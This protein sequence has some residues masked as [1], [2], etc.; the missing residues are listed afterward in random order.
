MSLRRKTARPSPPPVLAL[1]PVLLAA[2]AAAAVLLRRRRSS[3]PT[4]P[5]PNAPAPPSDAPAQSVVE[6]TWSC[7]CGED[8]RV[9]GQGIHRVYWLRDAAVSD[10]VMEG[11]CPSC[12]R[13]LPGE[14]V[15]A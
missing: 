4:G 13:P 15:T 1:L 14:H 7:A 2:A 5:D 9:S 8:Y 11:R 12:E 3:G 10:P 6:Q